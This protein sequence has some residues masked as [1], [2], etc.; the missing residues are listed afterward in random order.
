MG[1]EIKIN[2][3]EFELFRSN[4]SHRLKELG[5][6]EFAKEL[7]TTSIVEEYWN[8]KQ[9][10]EALYLVCMFDTI[11]EKYHMKTHAKF[12]EVRSHR[13]TPPVYPLEVCMGL[14]SKEGCEKASLPIFKEHG[15]M[16]VDIYSAC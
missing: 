7:L 5:D 11:C 10:L 14:D 12:S 15:I 3:A 6:Y 2:H 1:E 13:I 9:I 16:E 4:M 8:N